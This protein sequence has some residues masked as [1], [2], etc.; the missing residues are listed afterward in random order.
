MVALQTLAKLADGSGH[1]RPRARG[2][3]LDAAGL[4]RNAWLRAVRELLA[5]ELVKVTP[6]LRRRESSSYTVTTLGL[7]WLTG[8]AT[9]SHEVSHDE[10]PVLS[11]SSESLGSKGEAAAGLPG[12][13]GSATVSHDEPRVSHETVDRLIQAVA[14]LTEALA[15][16]AAAASS[17]VREEKKAEEPRKAEP[18]QSTGPLSASDREALDAVVS[19]LGKPDLAVDL[20]ASG[21]ALLRAKAPAN[22]VAAVLKRLAFKLETANVTSPTGLALKI[23]ED[24]TPEEEAAALEPPHPVKRELDPDRLRVLKTNLELAQSNG[25]PALIAKAEEA[26]KRFKEGA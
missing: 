6:S 11:S 24:M 26:L 15:K 12:S 25:R 16:N 10:P 23:H 2:Q 19:S 4:D 9:A 1:V 13:R 5:K 18:V 7:S 17:G 3:L 21:A 14:A 22:R 8:R 20:R